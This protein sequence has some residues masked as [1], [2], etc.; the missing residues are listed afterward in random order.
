MVENKSILIFYH[1]QQHFEII[2]IL[3]ISGHQKKSLM[4]ILIAEKS[5]YSYIFLIAVK[6]Y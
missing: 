4:P 3:L 6:C 5:C 1:K 2:L